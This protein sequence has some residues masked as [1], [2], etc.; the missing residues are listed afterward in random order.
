MGIF[1]KIAVFFSIDRRYR[2]QLRDFEQCK[3]QYNNLQKHFDELF[4]ERNALSDRLHAVTVSRDK[5]QRTL[6][7][8]NLE[9][10]ALK[11][12]YEKICKE[13]RHLERVNERLKSR[14]A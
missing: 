14:T 8:L 12:K 5:L 3:T 6:D 7:K 9:L 1:K 4:D 13:N 11:H 10:S 2:R